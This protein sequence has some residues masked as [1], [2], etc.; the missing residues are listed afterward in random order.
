MAN[1]KDLRRR[2][3]STKSSQKITSAMK[4]VSASKLRRAQIAV[5]QARPYSKL[6][7]H[8]VADLSQAAS[9]LPH[10]LTG[11]SEAKTHLLILF[12]SDRGLCGGLNTQLARLVRRNI[13]DLEGKNQEV[14]LW[15]S[16]KKLEDQLRKDYSKQIAKQFHGLSKKGAQFLEARH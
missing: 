8:M 14:V 7:Q 5:E 1:L 13:S 4:M 15:I 11:R 16:G 12:G 3:R 10:L 6:V 9:D 2:I